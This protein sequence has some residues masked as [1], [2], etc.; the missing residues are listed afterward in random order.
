M[1]D[2]DPGDY[3]I[4]D[5]VRVAFSDS[6]LDAL[7]KADIVPDE[8]AI[9]EQVRK[10]TDNEQAEIEG[11]AREAAELQDELKKSI[12]DKNTRLKSLRNQL[13]EKMILHG[14]K[15]VVINGRPP[16]ELTSSSSRKASRKSII[17]VLED[18]AV[19]KLTDDQRRDPRQLKAAQKQGKTNALN[20]WNKIPMTDSQSVK[21]PDPAPAEMDSPY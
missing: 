16:I 4:G 18:V 17:E 20:L 13:K 12:G 6:P 15:E 7:A 9:E 3:N 5:I 21:I 10:A 14:L 19:G 2:I 8:P 11:L 1:T